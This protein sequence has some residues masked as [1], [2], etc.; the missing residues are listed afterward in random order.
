MHCPDATSDMV[1]QSLLFT[2]ILDGEVRRAVAREM[3]R[4]V[5]QDGWILWY[6]FHVDN[7][8]N[9]DVR[10]VGR[11][12]MAALFPG[13]HIELQRLTLAPPLSRRGAPRAPPVWWLL[14]KV[15]RVF[16]PYLWVIPGPSAAHAGA[17]SRAGI[18]GCDGR[19]ARIKSWT[20]PHSH[21]GHAALQ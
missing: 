5:R 12:E 6:D 4:V 3:L 1:L 14:A 7:P 16:T 20:A 18:G 21:G 19:G 2:S 15:A 17:G 8:W 13:C 11:R 10:R 9:P